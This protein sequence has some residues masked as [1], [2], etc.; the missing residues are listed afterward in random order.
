MLKPN[1]T[2]AVTGLLIRRAPS[3]WGSI[4]VYAG[5]TQAPP[6]ILISDFFLQV[7]AEKRGYLPARL[8]G[9]TTLA[10]QFHTT[11]SLGQF[12]QF[13]TEGR[14]RI[15]GRVRGVHVPSCAGRKPSN[16]SQISGIAAGGLFVSRFVS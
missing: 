14:T 12:V 8:A 11:L 10:N 9:W 16:A 3:G 6:L 2:P 13:W 1:E 5:Y 4:I 7:E 15:E